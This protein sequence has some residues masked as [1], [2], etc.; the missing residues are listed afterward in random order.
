VTPD[1]GASW[2]MIG[3]EDASAIRAKCSTMPL[4]SARSVAP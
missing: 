1:S 3:S 4:S 2:T